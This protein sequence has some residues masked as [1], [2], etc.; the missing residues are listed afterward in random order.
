MLCVN[1]VVVDDVLST[2]KQKTVRSRGMPLNSMDVAILH[3]DSMHANLVL[4]ADPRADA[5]DPDRALEAF[6]AGCNITT[7][8]V[9]AG[10]G[11][12]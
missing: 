5:P 12:A 3:E 7:S 4:T 11:D 10:L 6:V 1:V 9:E 8:A 2:V